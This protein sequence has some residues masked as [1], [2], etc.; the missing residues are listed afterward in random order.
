MERGTRRALVAVAVVGGVALTTGLVIWAARR[1]GGRFGRAALPRSKGRVHA[2]GMTL[3]VYRQ[4]NLP[5]QQRVAIIQDLVHKGVRDPRMRKLALEITHHCPARDGRCEARAVY[6]WVR[7]NVRY[8]GDIG[9]HRL[10]DGSVEP[11]DLFQSAAR[12]VE[13]RAGDCDD[14]ATL[15]SVLL[16]LNGIPARLRI[17]SRLPG[18]QDDFSHIFAVAGVPKTAPTDWLAVDSTLPGDN[19]GREAPYAKKADFPA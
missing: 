4:A 8:S 3:T 9:P 6:D 10:P 1:R 5:I 18:R 16:L 2:S 7:R 14:S 17:T 12:T 11:V 15:S 19:F 13:F